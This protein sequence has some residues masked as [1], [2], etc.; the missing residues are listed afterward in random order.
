MNISKL[1]STFTAIPHRT[2]YFFYYY[3]CLF[4]NLIFHSF[5]YEVPRKINSNNAKCLSVCECVGHLDTTTVWSNKSSQNHHDSNTG[6]PSLIKLCF[7]PCLFNQYMFES[8]C[9]ITCHAT[10]FSMVCKMNSVAA[11]DGKHISRTR[12]AYPTR[13]LN[14]IFSEFCYPVMWFPIKNQYSSPTQK[15]WIS[16]PLN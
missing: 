2:Y 11:E 6:L 9:C 4:L 8:L 15:K 12:N 16:R 14:W 1:Y 7:F 13:S 10:A 5:C 3:N